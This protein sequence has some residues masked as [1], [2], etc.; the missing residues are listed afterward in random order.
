MNCRDYP[1][2][3][4]ITG[5]PIL[6]NIAP[7]VLISLKLAKPRGIEGIEGKEGIEGIK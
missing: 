4:V 1:P 3:T 2:S 6:D 5:R 7:R